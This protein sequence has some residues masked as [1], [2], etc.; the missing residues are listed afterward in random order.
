MRKWHRHSIHGSYIS[1]EKWAR[2]L[3]SQIIRG[4]R[5]F[6]FLE[7]TPTPTIVVA[8]MQYNF[9]HTAQPPPRGVRDVPALENRK[10]RNNA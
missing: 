10:E 6:A 5:L 1:W 3:R 8:N 4:E 9:R 2:E 7:A